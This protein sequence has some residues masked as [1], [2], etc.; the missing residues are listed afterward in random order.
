MSSPRGSAPAQHSFWGVE[1]AQVVQ[2]VGE[3]HLV[4]DPA[5]WPRGGPEHDIF[6]DDD[7]G[8]TSLCCQCGRLYLRIRRRVP[9]EIWYFLIPVTRSE[10]EILIAR[11]AASEPSYTG[12]W[13]AA[14]GEIVALASTRPFLERSDNSPKVLH[15]KGPGE[16]LAFKFAPW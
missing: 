1:R 12:R 4:D 13:L 14:E 2:V 11:L 6:G 16:P 9:S 7:L 5:A 8:V 10:V 15:W 3:C